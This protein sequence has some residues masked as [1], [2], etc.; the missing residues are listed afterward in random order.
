M[1]TFLT[2]TPS[3]TSA[4]WTATRNISS[5][6]TTPP[7]EGSPS[8]I[9]PRTFRQSTTTSLRLIDPGLPMSHRPSRKNAFLLCV[10]PLALTACNPKETRVLLQP[11]Q[12]L[13]VVLS[14]QTAQLA[15]AKRR[16]AVI[17]PD[18]NWG[19]TSTVEESFKPALQKQGCSVVTAKAADLGDPMRSAVG[20]L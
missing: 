15:G 2:T 1:K 10:L 5:F 9:S 6:T 19:P 14:E 18:G 7:W 20:G 4:R 13:G 8:L 3:I 16:I 11:S 17:S 12:A